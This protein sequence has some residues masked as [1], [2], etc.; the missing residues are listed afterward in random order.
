MKTPK[1][2]FGAVQESLILDNVPYHC[3]D[4]TDI[5]PGYAEVD[6]L[7]DDNGVMIDCLLTAGIVGS[8]IRDSKDFGLQLHG[9]GVRDVVCP[10]VGWWMYEKPSPKKKCEVESK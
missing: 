2:S 3:I 10:L 9:D 8:T 1:Q 6:V 5:P 4:T 7:L